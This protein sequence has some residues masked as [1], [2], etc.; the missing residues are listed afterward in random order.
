MDLT[1]I[2]NNNRNV[3]IVPYT[4]QGFLADAKQ[5]DPLGLAKSM[6]DQLG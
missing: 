6:H 2:F 4:F 1:C 3:S 5:L